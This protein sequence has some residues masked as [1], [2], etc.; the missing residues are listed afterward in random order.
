[1]LSKLK[2][3]K[4]ALI[5]YFI[6][7]ILCLF[8]GRLRFQICAYLFYLVPVAGVEGFLDQLALEALLGAVWH[9]GVLGF[10]Y[11]WEL[12][13]RAANAVD[14]L[15]EALWTELFGLVAPMQ[16]LYSHLLYC[17]L[18]QTVLLACYLAKLHCFLT[19]TATFENVGRL[20]LPKSDQVA[21]LC[22]VWVWVY[23]LA[24][25]NYRLN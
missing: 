4:T 8:E 16:R 1:M 2:D 15:L 10:A 7:L 21:A 17:H 22:Q 25:V 3:F 11:L 12:Y 19:V 23:V 9:A 18:P 13:D 6:L 20:P 5:W 24:H 14:S